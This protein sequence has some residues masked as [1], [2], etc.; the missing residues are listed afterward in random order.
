MVFGVKLPSSIA[1][2]DIPDCLEDAA[3]DVLHGDL[4]GLA[5]NCGNLS[6]FASQA[7]DLVAGLDGLTDKAMVINGVI[8]KG[9]TAVRGSC[10]MLS[11]CGEAVMNIQSMVEPIIPLLCAKSNP[12]GA[13]QYVTKANME[14]AIQCIQSVL[15]LGGLLEGIS[16]VLE[17]VK[18]AF[19]A[20]QD[21]AQPIVD[22]IVNFLPDIVQAFAEALHFESALNGIQAFFG[23]LAG[24]VQELGDIGSVLNPILDAWGD[25][26]FAEIKDLVQEKWEEML[27]AFDRFFPSWEQAQ[28]LFNRG[29]DF[30]GACLTTAFNLCQSF[31]GVVGE[32]FNQ[33]GMLAPDWAHVAIQKIQDVAAPGGVEVQRK[34][35]G[36]GADTDAMLAGLT[37]AMQQ[38]QRGGGIQQIV[39]AC[40]SRCM[41]PGAGRDT[42]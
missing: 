16:S 6:E 33:A 37:A 27:G 14:Q 34:P 9:S 15:D 12:L 24:L 35:E 31:A 30:A 36:C 19:G 38:A 10:N 17:D 28:D 32:I 13:W 1:G 8:C 40:F 41:R 11:S 20:I 5:A 22:S 26:D 23:C 25:K 21:A 7:A 29:K 18:T 2:V 3:D 39:Q 4:Q 42:E